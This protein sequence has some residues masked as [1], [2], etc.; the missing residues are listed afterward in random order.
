MPRQRRRRRRRPASTAATPDA[1]APPTSTSRS[2][3]DAVT[4][5]PWWQPTLGVFIAFFAGLWLGGTLSVTD[6]A[7]GAALIVGALG[8]GSGLAHLFGRR[9]RARKLEQ[10]QRRRQQ[11]R[12]EDGRDESTYD[13]P[14][15]LDDAPTDLT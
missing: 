10:I 2:L 8:A 9:L 5:R 14:P 12:A 6:V 13:E 15:A 3:L 1:A 4:E 7:S 11:Q